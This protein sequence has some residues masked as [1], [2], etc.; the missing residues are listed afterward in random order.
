MPFIK[1]EVSTPVNKEQE[2]TIKSKLGKA[3]QLIPGKTEAGLMVEIVDNCKL[4][5]GGNKDADTAYVKVEFMGTLAD[6]YSEK[7]TAAICTLLEEEL[8]IPQKRV[9]IN[10][11][12]FK[13][14]GCNGKNF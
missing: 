3:I 6:E 9:Y 2:E 5:M 13:Q 12:S 11:E 10:Y 8:H 1:A 14:W 4:Y 7:I